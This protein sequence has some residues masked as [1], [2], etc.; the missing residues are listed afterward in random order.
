VEPGVF[1][2]RRKKREI[3]SE[4]KGTLQKSHV[5]LGTS[6]LEISQKRDKFSFSRGIS[7]IQEKL[8]DAWRSVPPRLREIKRKDLFAH[9]DE[10]GRGGRK[11]P[12]EG[13]KKGEK[14][15]AAMLKKITCSPP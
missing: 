14:Y 3:K 8:R 1:L 12:I 4:G 7:G 9:I 10:K 11:N 2:T 6:R 15:D 13:D 5:I